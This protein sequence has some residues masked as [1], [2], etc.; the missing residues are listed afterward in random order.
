MSFSEEDVIK[1]FFITAK[2]QCECCKKKLVFKNRDKGTK[3][4]WHAHHVIPKNVKFND[5]IIN[6]AI[7]CINDP[8]NC[9]LNKGHGGNWKEAQPK[10]K[11]E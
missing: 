8:E 10:S 5:S 4:A 7:L 2:G 1:R 9:H 11:Q 6:M 3:G